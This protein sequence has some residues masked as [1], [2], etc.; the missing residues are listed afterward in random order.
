MLLDS[1]SSGFLNAV[2]DARVQ[3]RGKTCHV[4]YHQGIHK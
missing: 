2:A 4:F 1:G 3:F